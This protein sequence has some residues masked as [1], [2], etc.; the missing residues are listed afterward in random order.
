MQFAGHFGD[1]AILFRLA[2][3]IERAQPWIDRVPAVFL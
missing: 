2:G 1:E 3:Q